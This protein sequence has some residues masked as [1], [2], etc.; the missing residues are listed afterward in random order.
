MSAQRAVDLAERLLPAFNNGAGVPYTAISLRTGRGVTQNWARH[1]TP[2]ADAG[3]LALEWGTL[4]VLT[5]RQIF[6]RAGERA[7]RHIMSLPSRDGLLRHCFVD[8]N[9]AS[10]TLC[11]RIDNS[12]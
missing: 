9:T 11:T 3:T 2:V 7:L 1:K 10:R 6:R 5:N 12:G 8:T 4:G